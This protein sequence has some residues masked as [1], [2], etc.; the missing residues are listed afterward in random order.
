[1]REYGT[2]ESFN[3]KFRDERLNADWFRSRTE[4]KTVI[5]QWRIH[6]NTV[7]PHQSLNYLTPSEFKSLCHA[8]H[9]GAVQN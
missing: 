6:Y 8:S 5:E 4:A 7:R 9:Q 3:G 2:N 1:L